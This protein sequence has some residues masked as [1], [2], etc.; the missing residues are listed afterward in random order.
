MPHQVRHDNI[1]LLKRSRF[2][3]AAWAGNQF[4]GRIKPDRR[5]QFSFNAF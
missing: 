2:H 1:D 5:Q 4:G 3:F